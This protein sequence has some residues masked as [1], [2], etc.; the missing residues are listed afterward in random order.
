MPVFHGLQF[1][2]LKSSRE[3]FQISAPAWVE[4]WFERLGPMPHPVRSASGVKATQVAP[5]TFLHTA[6]MTLLRQ[7]SS[8]HACREP[9]ADALT[10]ILG[11]PSPPP[12]SSHPRRCEN[13][14]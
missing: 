3:R 7:G 9:S 14:K 5:P 10:T 4:L 6:F 12:P 13:N 1:E 11:P 2:L 8:D